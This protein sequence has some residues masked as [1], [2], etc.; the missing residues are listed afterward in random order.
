MNIVI[1]GAGTAGLISALIIKEKY[2]FN[3]ITVIKSGDIGI[4]GVGEGSTEHWRQFMDFV[5][6]EQRELIYKTKATIKIGIL[7]KN[8]VKDHEYVHTIGDHAVSPLSRLDMYHHLFLESPN[9]KFPLSPGFERSFYN[10]LVPVSNNLNISNQFHFDTFKLNEYLLELCQKQGIAIIDA[11]ITEVYQDVNGSITGLRSD[12][13][14]FKGDFFIDCSGFKRV[15]SSKLGNKFVSMADYLPM[16]HAIAFPTE[17]DDPAE[18]EPYTLTTALSAGWLWK[19]PT[20]ERY[21]NGMYLAINI[22]TLIKR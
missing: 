11:V 15:I 14:T 2:P 16:N 6:I 7:F 22:L 9:E 21:G 10:N 1:L 4:I 20:Q 18:I 12:K 17:L 8:W 3:N 5:G 13:E 19:I